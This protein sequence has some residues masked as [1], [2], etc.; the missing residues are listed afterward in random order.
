MTDQHIAGLQVLAGDQILAVYHT[1]RKTC[2]VILVLRH[3]A[4][5]LCRLAADQSRALPDGSLPQ[6]PLR[7]P[8]SSPD[9]S[10]RRQYSPGRTD[11][12]PPAQATSFTHIA[13]AVNTDRVML[14]HHEKPALTFVPQPSVPESNTGS[15]MFLNAFALEERAGEAAQTAQYFRTH[16]L[17]LHVPSSVLP[18]VYPASIS[19]P[20]L[21]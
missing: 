2:Q 5:V 12:S 1:Y 15:S 7:Y 8:R 6:R 9:N 16:G 21:L 14:I 17:P 20:A 3:Q 19:T 18:N 4:R 11:G 13:T 10:C